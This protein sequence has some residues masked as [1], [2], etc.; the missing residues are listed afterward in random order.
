MSA[1]ELLRA[2]LEL[3]AANLTPLP[4]RA[5]GSKAP[6][7]SWAPYQTARPDLG[8]VVGWFNAA[9]ADGLGIVTGVPDAGNREV[10]EFEGRAVAEGH[11]DRFIALV[12]AAGLTELWTRVRTGY[13]ALSPSGGHHYHLHVDGPALGNTKLARRPS[14]DAELEAHPGNRVQVLVETRGA[15]GFIVTPPS[16][17][18]THPTGRAWSVLAGAPG[19][20]ATV[21]PTE[22][23]QLYALARQ[24]DAMPEAAPATAEPRTSTPATGTRPGDDFNA[25]ASWADVLTPHG[26]TLAGRA[27][28]E[29]LWTRPGKNPRDGASATSGRND[30]DNLYVFTTST[31]L[32]TEEPLTKFHAYAL[33][34]HAGDHKAAARALAAAGYGTP[35]AEAAPVTPAERIDPA[36][37]EVLEDAAE[38]QLEEGPEPVPLTEAEAV[39]RRWLGPEYDLD[40]MR[41]VVATAAAERLDGDPLWLLVLSGSGNAKTETVQALDGIAATITSTVSSPGALLSGTS[42][43]ER[44]KDATGGL[45]AKMGP[46]GVL[47]IKD[48]TSILSM[49]RD[50]RA[51]VLAALREVYDGRWSRNL[52]SDGGQT[53]EWSGRLALI[54]AVTTAW[55]TAHAV[56]A[57]MGDRFVVLRMDSSTG[58]QAAGR[59]AIA[60]TG[61]ETAMRAELAAAVAGVLAGMDPTPVEL[62]ESE[63]AALLSAADLVTLARTAVEFDYRG[64]VIDAH[65][66]EMPT[67]FAK[68]LAQVVRGAVAVGMTR[69]DALRLAVRCARDSMPPL[70][71]AIVDDL[72][73]HPNSPTAD[74]RRRIG[75]PRA[76]V[77]RQLQALHMLGVVECDEVE[78]GSNS[79][80]TR[81]FYSLAAGIDPAALDAARFTR[82]VS[83]DTHPLANP[84]SLNENTGCTDISGKHS[85]ASG[86]ACP[87]CAGPIHADRLA[88]GLPCL[89]CYRP[90]CGRYGPVEPPDLGGPDDGSEVQS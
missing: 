6:A 50:T 76:T 42:R 16:N 84:S 45:L 65:A 36:T 60:N 31:E 62:T 32:P 49:N 40:A 58:R 69:D 4:V 75:K 77:D 29:L 63:A 55:D 39:F 83:R 24:L 41:A 23:D 57:S 68:Q 70:R 54:G 11:L 37:G 87:R 48:V 66:P 88:A 82:N 19:D 3:H 61:H 38:P 64:D 20:A 2:A 79:D 85:E 51:E 10:M 47:V 15:G 74:V 81:W 30:A 89:D 17:G 43:R 59:R 46:R 78:W 9:D 12:E 13:A 52:G 26:W 71:L 1:T 56:I 35:R 21:T 18:R 28:R 67:R 44:S 8:T 73:A 53:L 33:L 34:E 22:R 72:A 5:D 90:D 7:V 27:G 86:G 25:R 14:T 80:R